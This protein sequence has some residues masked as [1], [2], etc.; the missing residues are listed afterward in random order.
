MKE[1][2]LKF[3]QDQQEWEAGIISDNKCWQGDYPVIY[4]NHHDKM[5]DL[6][7]RRNILIKEIIESQGKQLT[8]V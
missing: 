8:I 1:K 2:M 3:L 5:I 4:G 7:T 6:Q